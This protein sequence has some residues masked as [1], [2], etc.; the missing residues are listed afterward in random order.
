MTSSGMADICKRRALMVV[1][2][3]EPPI[4]KKSSESATESAAAR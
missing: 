1:M 2:S 3:V 4:C